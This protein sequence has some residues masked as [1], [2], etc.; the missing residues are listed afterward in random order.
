MYLWEG[1]GREGD[2]RLLVFTTSNRG[3]FSQETG[4]EAITVFTVGFKETYLTL[5][6]TPFSFSWLCSLTQD[7]I[8]DFML[9]FKLHGLYD[10]FSPS[11]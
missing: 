7:F 3:L 2:Y 11:A 9:D 8:S 1:T 6:T 10:I 4:F 5:E